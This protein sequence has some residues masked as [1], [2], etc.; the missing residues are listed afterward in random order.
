MAMAAVSIVVGFMPHGVLSVGEQATNE[1]VQMAE[2]P[3]T[4]PTGCMDVT[5]G[6]GTPAPSAPSAAIVLAVALAAVVGAA[7]AAG[8]S[9]RRRA[10]A[11]VLPA[12]SRVP[13]FHPPRFS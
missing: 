11:A 8:A 13:L 5:C 2:A 7:A 3:V 10:R 9:R 1:V 6:K 12:G 4:V